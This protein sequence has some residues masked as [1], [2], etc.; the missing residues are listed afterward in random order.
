MLIHLQSNKSP[1]KNRIRYL[2]YGTERTPREPSKAEILHGDPVR[3]LL[4]HDNHDREVK[5]YNLLITFKENKEE[6]QKKLS[7]KGKTLKDLH[8]EILTFLLPYSLE[9]VNLLTVAH[10]DTAHYHWHIT[11]DNQHLDN[12]KS[13]YLPRT[14]LTIRLYDVLRRYISAKYGISLGAPQPYGVEVGTKKL[15]EKLKEKGKEGITLKKEQ[16]KQLITEQITALILSGDINSRKDIEEY[17]EQVLGLQINRRGKSYISIRYGKTKIRLSGGIYDEQRFRQLAE[18][19][20]KGERKDLYEPPERAGELERELREVAEKYR[21]LVRRRLRPSKGEIQQD[22]RPDREQ[23]KGRRERGQEGTP[24]THRREEVHLDSHT[25]KTD[26][27]IGERTLLNADNQASFQA[28]DESLEVNPLLSSSVGF[29]SWRDRRLDSREGVRGRDG[30]EG[31]RGETGRS[32]EDEEKLQAPKTGMGERVEDRNHS[33]QTGKFPLSN[34][35][36][37]FR[38]EK[39]NLDSTTRGNWRER[40][41]NGERSR[42]ILHSVRPTPPAPHR[43]LIQRL[44]SEAVM[45]WEAKREK[46]LEAIKKI[47]PEVIFEDLGIDSRKVGHRLNIYAPWR[48]E[49]KP[50]VFIEQKAN[51]HWVWKD[52]GSGKGGTWIDFFMELYG[53]DYVETVRYLRERYLGADLELMKIAELSSKDLFFSF[54]SRKYELV[55]L[56][57]KGVTHPALKR[58]LKERGISRI[59][60]WLKEVHYQLKDK[61]TGEIRKYFALGVQTVTGSWILRNPMV[62]MNLRTSDEQKHSFAYLGKGSKRLVIVEGL[63]DA[64]SV[65]Q[66]ARRGDFDLVILSGIENLKKLLRGEILE[67]YEEIFVGT[68]KDEAGERAFEE[69][70]AYLKDRQYLKRLYRIAFENANDLNEAIVTGE[71]IR[72]VDCTEKLERELSKE[73]ERDNDLGPSLGM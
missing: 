29:L 14:K 10:S 54:S 46:E 16:V 12:G 35:T 57:A 24:E 30:T 63:F 47:P 71:D 39:R 36:D 32:R 34:I 2:L 68:D 15:I 37:G 7:E 45:E 27:G 28:N 73:R 70:V 51:G 1:L 53:W 21:D 61:E 17:I 38:E 50:S 69:I 49:T 20:R 8:D 6:L 66:I 25:T 52:F 9:E 67:R 64:L 18:E 59:P 41:L 23:A 4:I 55:D 60:S 56:E 42:K 44:Y 22:R 48:E 65:Y 58:Y 31:I 26:S 13:L 40:H 72:L 33:R 5:S 19:I 43:T 11:I 62:K 3:F